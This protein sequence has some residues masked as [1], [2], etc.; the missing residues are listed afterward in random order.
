MQIS[1]T[2]KPP[3]PRIMLVFLLGILCWAVATLLFTSSA[4]YTLERVLAATGAYWLFTAFTTTI[5]GAAALRTSG[6]ERL[7]WA[8]LGAGV[9]AR[10]AGDVIW[11]A[12]SALGFP[13]PSPTPQEMAYLISYLLLFSAL[14]WLV[15]LMKSRMMFI[16]ALDALSVMLSTGILF[17]YFILEPAITE[18]EP[19]NW[20][21]IFTLISQPVSNLGLFFLSLIALTA[22]NKPSFAP[23]LSAGF[24]FFL[25]AD[26]TYLQISSHEPYKSGNW[27]ELLWATGMLL[28][29][30]AALRCNGAP[31]TA[32]PR[33]SDF[34]VFLFWMGPLSPLLQYGF[35]LAWGAVYPPLPAYALLGGTALAVILALRMFLITYVNVRLEREERALARKLEQHRIS[36]ELH[37]NVKQNVYGISAMLNACLEAQRKQDTGT[38]KELLERSLTASRET[39]YQVTKP[40]GELQALCRTAGLPPAALLRQ[41]TRE[42]EQCF[43]FKIQE[44]LQ[45]PLEKLNPE[46]FAATYRIVSEAL[47]NSVK[48]SGASNIR[49]IS[50]RVGST[51]IVKVK[52]DGK[53]F[54]PGAP[55][56]GIGLQLM[57]A[58]AREAGIQL[59]VIS[60]PGHGTTVL[61][62]FS[63]K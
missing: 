19:R 51:L 4:T 53:G 41:L 35:V 2:L 20:W 16:F 25:T 32:Q 56:S 8:M 17:G 39:C 12:S 37:D 24:F 63:K 45:N 52:D 33:S 3:V 44:D 9:F 13:V 6:A 15:R 21:E 18:A 38:V 42:F 29:S 31:F 55:P 11:S 1:K 7:F 23:F 46:E 60:K 47:W 10:L 30:F 27:P 48:H 43:G 62:G 61:L 5:L 36:A 57:F 22:K 26:A 28:L 14:L 49:L 40:I 34:A 50:L 58:N 54:D 59:D